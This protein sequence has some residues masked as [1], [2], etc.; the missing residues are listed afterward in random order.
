MTRRRLLGSSAAALG[1]AGVGAGIYGVAEGGERAQA[2]TGTDTVA[3]DGPRQA[4]IATAPPQAHAVFVGL[5]LLPRVGPAELVGIMKVW[6]ADI[7]RLT[8]GRPALA[9][10]EPELAA[11]P[12]RLTVTVGF[13]PGVFAALGRPEAAPPWLAPLP[14]FAIDRLDP[15]YTGA[16]LALQVCA[17]DPVTVAHAVRVLV[18]NVRSLL[19]VRWTQRGFRRARGT[20][21]PGAT[22][23]NLMGQVDGT[24]NP[25][26]GTADFDSL[27]WDDG[28]GRPWMREG[29]SMVLRRIRIELDTWDELDRPGRELSVGRTLTTGAPLTGGRE[30]DEPDFTATDRNGIPVIPPSA[31]IARARHTRSGERIFRRVYNYDDPPAP[32]Q[33]SNSGLLFV[34]FQRDITSQF[35]PIQRRLDE[36]DA[37][38]EWTTPVGSAVFAI[39]PGAGSGSYIGE[40]LLGR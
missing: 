40:G 15:A 9:D 22:M 2:A 14:A 26:P 12:A 19:T 23:R 8:Q 27:V 20:E 33:V 17:D 35:L 11:A 28:A 39:P 4:G 34:S 37:L 16:D 7:A 21:L 10:T 38:N 24:A 30:T 5:D 13:G 36:F 31:H 18:K 25:E 1:A 3:W 6:T 29:T 32:G